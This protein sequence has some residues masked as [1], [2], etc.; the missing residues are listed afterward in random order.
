MYISHANGTHLKISG[1]E[2]N[3]CFVIINRYDSTA[4]DV[5]RSHPHYKPGKFLDKNDESCNFVWH[6]W[7]EVQYHNCVAC[8]KLLLWC[9]IEF[10]SD[11]VENNI[12]A[13]V[14]TLTGGGRNLSDVTVLEKY[15]S[16]P[17]DE[18]DIYLVPSIS[19]K[20]VAYVLPS[21]KHSDTDQTNFNLYFSSNPNQ[22]KHFMIIKPVKLWK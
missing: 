7:V 12:Y 9:W 22:N 1:P 8:G 13:M 21:I 4:H 6:D 17:V 14:Q 11:D 20:S 19:I 3:K 10:L 5:L 15:D 2:L 16:M 18:N